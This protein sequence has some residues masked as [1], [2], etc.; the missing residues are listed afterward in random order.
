[1]QRAILAE[2]WLP[3]FARFLIPKSTALQRD[4]EDYLPLLSTGDRNGVI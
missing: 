4:L 1:V 2:C 3:S